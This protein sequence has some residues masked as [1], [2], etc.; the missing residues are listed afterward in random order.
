M[1]GS[2]KSLLWIGV[3][4][5]F[6]F[7]VFQI[8][9]QKQEKEIPVTSYSDEAKQLFI[10]ARD[11]KKI[12]SSL[13]RTFTEHLLVPQPT[14]LK[15]PSKKPLKMLTEHQKENSFSYQHLKHTIGKRTM[16]R[17]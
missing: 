17:L 13:K 15:T 9:C 16:L 3:S 5:L 11:K 12:R 2:T 10:E 4:I 1:K 8:S 7:F 6:V 14:R